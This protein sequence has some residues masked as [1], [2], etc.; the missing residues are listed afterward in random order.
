MTTTNLLAYAYEAHPGDQLE[1]R[2][3]VG[4]HDDGATVTI[5][6]STGQPAT[7]PRL[8]EVTLVRELAT[9]VSLAEQGRYEL[10]KDVPLD[11]D[12]LDD[13]DDTLET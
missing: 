6:H 13:D 8:A 7:L 10:L 3:V 12:L 11:G 2:T 4:V 1:G 5:S 9:V